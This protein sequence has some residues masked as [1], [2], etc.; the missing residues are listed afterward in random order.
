MR[1]AH[2]FV[3]APVRRIDQVVAI[4]FDDRRRP[5]GGRVMR[6]MDGMAEAAGARLA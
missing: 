5:A 6:R 1:G 3:V 4:A 2:R